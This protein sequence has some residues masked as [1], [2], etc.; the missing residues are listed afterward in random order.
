MSNRKTYYVRLLQDDSPGLAEY[1]IRNGLS[2]RRLS[3][4]LIDGKMTHMYAMDL[5]SNEMLALK[6]SFPLIG[7]MTLGAGRFMAKTTL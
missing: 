3:I 1:I 7:C 2:C 4:D 5:I 6:I